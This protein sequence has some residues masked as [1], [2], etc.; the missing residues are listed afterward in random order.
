[1]Q[2]NFI[3]LYQQS[4]SNMSC[5][6]NSKSPPHPKLLFRPSIHWYN[7]FWQLSLINRKVTTARKYTGMQNML[8]IIILLV[9]SILLLLLYI[10]S[11]CSLWSW[12]SKTHLE[13]CKLK[14]ISF[15]GFVVAVQYIRFCMILE[16]VLYHFCKKPEYW[17]P[18]WFFLAAGVSNFSGIGN[19]NTVRK[20]IFK[21]V[22][23][24]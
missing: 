13:R 18:F 19:G 23:V 5:P 17:K 1:M 21:G 2:C 3:W 6:G 11:Y 10:C 7:K 15:M 4:V 12:L 8:L 9:S 16:L 22:Y 20:N 24:E 14:I